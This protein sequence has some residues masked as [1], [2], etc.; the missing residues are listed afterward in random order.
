M[1]GIIIP[2]NLSFIFLSHPVAEQKGDKFTNQ[3]IQGPTKK[4]R[5]CQKR[6]MVRVNN[7]T[8]DIRYKSLT[9][10]FRFR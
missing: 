8:V 9:C 4:S 10:K 5:R 3:I 2:I 6:C 7:T 1:H